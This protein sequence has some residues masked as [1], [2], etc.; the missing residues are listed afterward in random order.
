M[1]V[2]GSSVRSILTR[3]VT[4]WLF[5]GSQRAGSLSI[6]P[7]HLPFAAIFP[8]LSRHQFLFIHLLIDSDGSQSHSPVQITGLYWSI[9]WNLRCAIIAQRP[10]TRGKQLHALCEGEGLLR[11]VQSNHGENVKAPPLSE[12]SADLPLTLV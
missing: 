7:T 9:D 10:R 12:S 3:P 8:P 4:F 6:L 11:L 1:R 2:G 5:I